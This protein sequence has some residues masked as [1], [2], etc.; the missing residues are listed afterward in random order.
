MK[1][2][3]I[4]EKLSHSFSAPIHEGFGNRNYE[5][6]SL[7]PDKLDGFLR[8]RNFFGLNVTIPY[9][10][11]VMPYCDHISESA[12]KI[13]SVNTL[14]IDGADMMTGHNTDYNG[15]SKLAAYAN[16]T[17]KGKKVAIFG[18]GGTS[19]TAHAVVSDEG[20]TDVLTVSRSGAV[21]YENIH[22]H[23]DLD[24][25]INTTPVGMYPNNGVS[26]IDLTLFPA[27]RGV[28][29]VVYNPLKTAV[30][31]QA[32]S[33]GIPRTG[34]LYMLVVQAAAAEELF[35]SKTIGASD[36]LRVFSKLISD[37]TN[38]VLIGMPGSGKT[39]IGEGIAKHLGREFVDTDALIVQKSDM[40]IPDIFAKYGEGAFRDIEAEVIFEA[41]KK[42]GAV[43]AT[44]GGAVLR[45]ENHTSL[46][47]NGRIYFIRRDVSLLSGDGRPLSTSPD[48]LR[49]MERQRTPLYEKLCD[50]K[51]DNSGSLSQAVN[52]ILEEIHEY[53]SH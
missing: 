6:L 25:I 1:Y 53:F 33:M 23:R 27:L 37:M 35:M 39:T 22:E 29:D 8:M 51:I 26:P 28:I 12:Q 45:E 52:R 41:G 40:S 5:I 3:L 21:N 2:G 50:V 49:E 46:S 42:H 20:A 14:I 30:I 47:Q 31:L 38:I 34:G 24:I 36:C 43:I 17:F 7:P 15:F 32:E 44:G 18:S 19:M 13:G 48:A 16:I 9:K 10:K 11:A 4:G